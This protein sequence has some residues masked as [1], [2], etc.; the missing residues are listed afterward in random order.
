MLTISYKI[1]QNNS[2][3][4]VEISKFRHDRTEPKRIRTRTE[5]GLE[6]KYELVSLL[7]P[8]RIL[9]RFGINSV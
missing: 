5:P 9:V 7:K 8:E 6:S 4:T 3:I 2:F 1:D